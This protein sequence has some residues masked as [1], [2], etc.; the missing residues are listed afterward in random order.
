MFNF[1]RPDQQRLGT[2]LIESSNKFLGERLMDRDPETQRVL[3][4]TVI[5]A[6]LASLFGVVF[7]AVWTYVGDPRSVLL[8][9]MLVALWASLL[10]LRR[11]MWREWMGFVLGMLILVYWVLDAVLFNQLGPSTYA[12]IYLSPVAAFQ[13]GSKRMGRL[14]GLI[15]VVVASSLWFAGTQ[16]PTLL[17]EP[18]TFLVMLDRLG[19]L[20]LMASFMTVLIYEQL[21]LD[22]VLG[23]TNENM[24]MQLY[25][26]GM[27]KTEESGQRAVNLGETLA[28]VTHDLSNPLTYAVGNLDMLLEGW[29]SDEDPR[30]LMEDA[31]AGLVQIS[32]ILNGLDD[33]THKKIVVSMEDVIRAALRSTRSQI[34]LRARLV[35]EVPSQSTLVHGVPSR[36]VQVLV[37][38]LTNALQAT[39]RGK[40]SQHEIGI[41]TEVTST[42]VLI[43][44]SDTGHGIPYSIIDR[45]KEPFFTTRGSEQG[46]GLGL[47]ICSRIAGQHGGSLRFS[48]EGGGGTEV[49][50]SLPRL[51]DPVPAGDR[52]VGNDSISTEV[53]SLEV[54][55]VD[56]DPKMLKLVERALHSMQVTVLNDSRQVLELFEQR[57]FDVIVCDIMM[58][59]MGGQQVY[60]AVVAKYPEVSERFLFMT[61][62]A[63]SESAAE[64]V[65]LMSERMLMKPMRMAALRDRIV[66][67]ANEDACTV[68]GGA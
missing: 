9:A 61:G 47:A 16:N 51:R 37:N 67:V 10:V 44:V 52:R 34:E 41:R 45:V 35:V 54:L 23:Q 33:S 68:G 48:S 64:F 31:Y 57:T 17:G 6:G 39:P 21:F 40:R 65:G 8:T 15:S 62:G 53:A 60:E 3:R 20:M 1:S 7:I 55:V 58:P 36:L 32:E 59:N 24:T 22:R 56:D 66:Q 4:A 12:G 18:D 49:T 11:T 38:L 2:L 5:A 19:L 30:E 26:L 43:V 28:S 50:L 27:V 63:F 46:T 13:F 29:E 14:Y 42:H 25:R